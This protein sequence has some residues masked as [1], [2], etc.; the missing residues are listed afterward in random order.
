MDI[1]IPALLFPAISLLFIAFT[2]RLHTASA[3]I[4]SMTTE[5]NTGVNV[6]HKKEQLNFLKK[7]VA[8]IRSMQVFGILSFIFC[9]LTII[10][11]YLKQDVLAN[12]I[13][14]VGLLMLVSSLLFALAEILLSTK[15]LDIHLENSN[16]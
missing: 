5:E 14:G 6:Q 4:R 8:Y 11:F 16:Y 1:T 15:A 2:N 3:L 10:C 7:R 12:Y 9:L 13:F